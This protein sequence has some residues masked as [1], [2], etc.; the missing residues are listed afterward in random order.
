MLRIATAIALA[1]VSAHAVSADTHYVSKTGLNTPPYTSWETAGDSIKIVVEAASPYDTVRI[2]P[3]E[4]IENSFQI[5]TGMSL[6]GAG[7]DS[8][9]IRD[10]IPNDFVTDLI[11]MADSSSVQGLFLRGP[12]SIPWDRAIRFGYGAGGTVRNNRIRGFEYGV[13]AI[14]ISADYPSN[15]VTI[16]ENAIDACIIPVIA[17]SGYAVIRNNRI[18]L[19]SDFGAI[20]CTAAGP[21]IE[22]NILIPN[23]LLLSG[24]REVRR[25]KLAAVNSVISLVHCGPFSIRNNLIVGLGVGVGISDP[26]SPPYS[27]PWGAVENNTIYNQNQSAIAVS[28]TKV[29]VRNNIVSR[30]GTYKPVIEVTADSVLFNYNLLWDYGMLPVWDTTLVS[31]LLVAAPMFADTLDF[32]L[33]AY[34]PAI[35]AGDPTILDADG[36]RSDIGYTGGPGG[37]TYPYQDLPPAPPHGLTAT[38]TDSTIALLWRGNHESDLNHYNLYRDT[39]PIASASPA[40]LHAVVV[41]DSTYTDASI[42]AGQTYYYR[43]AALDNHMNTSG[44]SSEVS[45]LASGISRNDPITPSAFMLYPNYPNPFNASTRIRYTLDEPAHVQLSIYNVLGQHI[46]TLVNTSQP[47]GTHIVTWHAPNQPSGVYFIV[48]KAEDQSRVR[49]ALLLK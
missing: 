30:G 45:V 34:S 7:S 39:L 36:S 19:H 6:I 25:A 28:Q 4:Y 29:L 47:A 41:A 48:L 27:L 46:T 31:N 22:G 38:P 14:Y 12:G 23:P 13:N 18:T 1:I 44:L 40:L 32:L 8:T 5:K 16:E 10:T 9:T 15:V 33:Q 21:V 43:L 35:D 26:L 11:V 20:E 49:R 42:A 3:G 17:E 24:G 2:G 37:F